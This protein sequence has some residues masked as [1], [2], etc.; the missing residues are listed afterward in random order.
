MH[1]PYPMYNESILHK[2]TRTHSPY[3]TTHHATA[4]VHLKTRL[5]HEN[6]VHMHTHARTHAFIYIQRNMGMRK[7][8]S[9]PAKN[10]ILCLL[11]W[12]SAHVFWFSPCSKILIYQKSG[13]HS[14][15]FAHWSRS[16]KSLNSQRINAWAKKHEIHNP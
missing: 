12:Q 8:P 2:I 16:R 6:I 11:I 1:P 3:F 5:N 7:F 4:A 15:Q 10:F 9:M 14:K 13:D